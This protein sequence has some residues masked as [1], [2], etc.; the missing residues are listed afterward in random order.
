MA[1]ITLT[2]KRGDTTTALLVQL[3]RGDGTH[4]DLTGL[5]LSAIQ[6]HRKDLADGSVAS[7]AA[8][9]IVG[10]ATDAVVRYDPTPTDVAAVKDQE[11]EVEVTHLDS[12]VETFPVCDR[13]RWNIIPD[14]A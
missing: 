6:F 1:D 10:A 4:P 14:I 13:F 3:T 8:S 11:V 12:T 7:G 9:A 5:G 2:T